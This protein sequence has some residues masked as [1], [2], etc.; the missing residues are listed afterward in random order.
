VEGP[1][2]AIDPQGL[3][4]R[5]DYET[6]QTHGERSLLRLRLYTGRTHQIR[7]HMAALG[8][9]LVGDRLYGAQDLALPRP[10]LHSHF[11]HLI[12]PITG[13][14]VELS[15]PLPSDIKHLL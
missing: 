13:A 12:H 1:R 9:P 6:L 11:I 7:L 14:V 10:A 5:T 8:H 2:W 3:P 4:S 15:S